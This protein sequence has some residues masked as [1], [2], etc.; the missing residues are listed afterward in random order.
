MATFHDLPDE[1]RL[2]IAAELHRKT[3]YSLIR[4]CRSFYSSFIA[5]LWCDLSVKH[6]DTK[7]IDAARIRANA[8]LVEK[9][10]F[11]ATLTEEYY[12]IMFPQLRVLRLG[13]LYDNIT[14]P[15]Y[16]PANLCQKVEFARHHP[17]VQELVYFHK[18]SVRREFWEVV[19]LNW[20]DFES[21]VMSGTVE[22]DAAESFWR[23]CDRAQRLHFHGADLLESPSIMTKVSFRRLRDLAIRSYRWQKI[24][25]RQ[26][27]VQLLERA[28]GSEGLECL[29]WSVS[30]LRFP[31]EMVLEAFEEGCWPALSQLN[32]SDPLCSDE[33][34]AKV[35]RAL[36]SR[37]LTFFE[38]ES[39]RFGPSTFRCL[40]EFFFGH[41][42]QL[43]IGQCLGATSE[44]VQ[45]ILVECVHLTALD[46]PHVFVR[47]IAQSPK[48]W[49]CLGLE[50]LV[51][52][53]AKLK[54]DEDGWEGCV[55]EQISRLR[56]LT[57]LDLQSDPY[58][59]AFDDE[60]RPK[61]ILGLQTLD[62]RLPT[63]L[64]STDSKSTTNQGGS[65]SNIRCWSNLLQMK[66]FYFDDEKQELGI[67]ELVWMTEHWP[68]LNYIFGEFKAIKG[69]DC[70]RRDHIIREKCLWGYW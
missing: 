59:T 24:P 46:A 41:L 16:L 32:I 10:S 13:S 67:A 20:R 30:G 70:E 48:P 36:K 15:D 17:L 40:Q 29:A 52:F 53:I 11:H 2:I 50:K 66:E 42:K 43:E 7:A 51:V 34:M 31:V 19:D 1:I 55:F 37:K 18:D 33:D 54:R 49:G 3:I 56:R 22:E 8:H 25:V 68:S 26:W 45:M 28:K 62:L 27:P 58:C 44:M 39:G 69:A 47:D 6:H 65:G 60:P 21:L 12:H 63:L 23:V 35:L 4:V 64:V 38:Q 5:Q 57:I 9:V 61:A 14:E